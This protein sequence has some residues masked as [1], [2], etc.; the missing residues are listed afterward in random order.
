MGLT[1]YGAVFQWLVAPTL[2]GVNGAVAYIDDILIYGASKE[3]HNANLEEV[4][5]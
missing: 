4:L 2:A 3:K 5:S 1:D